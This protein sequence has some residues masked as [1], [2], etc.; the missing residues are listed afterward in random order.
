MSEPGFAEGQASERRENANKRVLLVLGHNIGPDS[1]REQIEND[2]YK[3]STYSKISA[4]AAGVMLMKNQADYVIF[5]SGKTSGN[6][7]PSEAQAMKDYLLSR[8]SFKDII[9]PNRIILEERSHDTRTNALESKKTADYFGFKNI[10]LMS[11]GRHMDN[12]WKIF[13]RNGF[14]IRKLWKSSEEIAAA[15]LEETNVVSRKEFMDFFQRRDYLFQYQIR[16]WQRELLLETF[17]P[18][19]EVL[20][21]VSGITRSEEIYN[22]KKKIKR[23]IG[24]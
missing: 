24:L 12:A 20:S 14:P 13:H 15:Y 5:S 1:G 18:K 21:K 7:L 8:R 19:G 10:R 17:D 9:D 6:D 22:L 23:S 4:F 11:I 2:H 16:E 3:L